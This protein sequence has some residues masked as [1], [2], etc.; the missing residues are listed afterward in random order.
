L[1]AEITEEMKFDQALSPHVPYF[2]REIRA[3]AYRQYLSSYS[4][5]KLKS[6]ANA[7][8]VT[9]EFIDRYVHSRNFFSSCFLSLTL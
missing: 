8:G 4:S 6:M 9:E 1:L 5:V 3:R 7:F 2:S